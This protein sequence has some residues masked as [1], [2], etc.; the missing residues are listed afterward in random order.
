MNFN[1]FIVCIAL[2]GSTGVFAQGVA[3]PQ[4]STATPRLDQRELNQ[5]KRIEQGVGSG[6][7]TPR[8]SQRLAAREN[9]LDQAETK[10]KADGQVTSAERHRLHRIAAKDSRAIRRQKHDAQ[11]VAKP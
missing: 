6:Q 8:E 11:A 5:E 10:A 2:A 9:H 3:A 1:H 4:N 7:L